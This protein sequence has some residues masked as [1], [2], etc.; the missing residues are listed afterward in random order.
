MWL[1]LF[2]GGS[3]KELFVKPGELG[4]K[5]N[6]VIMSKPGWEHVCILLWMN[7]PQFSWIKEGHLYY[8]IKK[9]ISLLSHLFF[10]N[11]IITQKEIQ[12]LCMLESRGGR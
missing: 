6:K 11:E 12:K 7:K 3:S 2:G 5:N 8:L 10:I 4:E 1:C 9:I